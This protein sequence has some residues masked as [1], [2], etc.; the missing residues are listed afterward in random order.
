[1]KHTMNPY[2]APILQPLN[3][4]LE[5]VV[6]QLFSGVIGLHVVVIEP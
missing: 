1:M 5:T 3:Q 4:H 2:I 6:C